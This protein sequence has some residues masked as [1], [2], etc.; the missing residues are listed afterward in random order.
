MDI[1]TDNILLAVYGTLKKGFHNHYFLKSSE[2][3]GKGV[4]KD[5]YTMTKSSI[6]FVNETGSTPIKV[7]VYKISPITLSN[8]DLLEG[9]PNWY[10]RKEV[11][12]KIDDKLISAWLYFNNNYDHLPIV[13]DGEFKK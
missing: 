8:I 5:E 1:S 11:K 6:P 9:H 7:E 4:T 2:F 3:I 13:E 10:N 12:I